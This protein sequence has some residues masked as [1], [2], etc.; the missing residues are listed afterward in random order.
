M[1]ASS[2][3]VQFP[4]PPPPCNAQI[5]PKPLPSGL[6][7]GLKSLPGGQRGGGLEDSGIARFWRI[8]ALH[9][10]RLL[11]LPA[12]GR[13]AAN[14]CQHRTGQTIRMIYCFGG[15][16]TRERHILQAKRRDDSSHRARGAVGQCAAEDSLCS[17]G[18]GC[19]GRASRQG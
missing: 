18:T 9:A 16:V 4:N 10:G 8:R 6:P 7:G 13:P 5:L 14:F 15:F 11:S 3:A 19:H 2:T 1:P 12:L 17:V